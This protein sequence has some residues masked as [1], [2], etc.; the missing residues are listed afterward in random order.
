MRNPRV[1]GNLWPCVAVH[2]GSVVDDF[3]W[4]FSK[5]LEDFCGLIFCEISSEVLEIWDGSPQ[6]SLDLL[7]FSS[8]LWF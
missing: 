5:S 6:A 3:F 4:I 1:A 8:T 2:G 7:P